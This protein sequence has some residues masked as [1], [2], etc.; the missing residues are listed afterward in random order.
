MK[1]QK[2][3]NSASNFHLKTEHDRHDEDKKSP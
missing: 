2:I 1:S 3:L